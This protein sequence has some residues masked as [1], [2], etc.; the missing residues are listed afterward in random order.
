MTLCSVWR[1]LEGGEQGHYLEEWPALSYARAATEQGR[2]AHTD[3][4]QHSQ[5]VSR[6]SYSVQL[7]CIDLLPCSRPSKTLVHEK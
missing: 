7:M 6:S 5:C 4:P 3:I 1:S 2:T